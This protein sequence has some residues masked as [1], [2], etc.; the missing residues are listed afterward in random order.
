MAL[1]VKLRF[2]GLRERHSCLVL[3]MSAAVAVAV[4]DDEDDGFE[5]SAITTADGT[6]SKLQGT[7]PKETDLL[8]VS[9]YAVADSDSD[10]N[11]SSSDSDGSEVQQ[12]QE[13][14][15]AANEKGTTLL[16]RD[17]EASVY[18]PPTRKRVHFAVPEDLAIT[19]ETVNDPVVKSTSG[20]EEEEEDLEAALAAFEAEV[21]GDR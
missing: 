18:R 8:G 7:L 1:L 21:G 11:S 17:A 19:K 14:A 15:S 9:T 12:E 2:P 5:V 20:E 3:A 10:S 13:V 6:R 16:K 4:D